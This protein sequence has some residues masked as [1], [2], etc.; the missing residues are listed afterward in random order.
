[1]SIEKNSN[2]SSAFKIFIISVFIYAF[3]LGNMIPAENPVKHPMVL[4]PE[5]T[6]EVFMSAFITKDIDTIMAYIPDGNSESFKEWR[7]KMKTIYKKYMTDA[8]H[9]KKIIEIRVDK[10]QE[11][12]RGKVA[13]IIITIE[14][15][16]EFSNSVNIDSQGKPMATYR[17][18][19]LKKSE[20]SPW[21]FD[22]GGF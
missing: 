22:G 3:I 18:V 11:E 8:R 16:S 4:T 10:I 7:E 15:T 17:W 9:I 20:N 13:T 21:L 2:I 19:F 6:A 14:T 1:M 12:K 5:K